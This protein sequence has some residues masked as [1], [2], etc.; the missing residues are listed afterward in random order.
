MGITPPATVQDEVMAFL[1]TSPTPQQ[2]VD[3]HASPAAQTRLRE[4]LDANQD[5]ALTADESI[6]LA[7]ASQIN[8]FFSMLKARAHEQ[9]RADGL[10][11]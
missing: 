6:E 3:F 9:L 2:I 10:H 11:L 8:F 4:L 1:L 5:D 7:E